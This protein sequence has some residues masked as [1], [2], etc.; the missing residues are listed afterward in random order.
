MKFH[1]KAEEAVQN[2]TLYNKKAEEKQTPQIQP[3]KKGTPK[4]GDSDAAGKW[5]LAA[6]GSFVLAGLIYYRRRRWKK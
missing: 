1:V 6:A 3:D 4:T 5:I 2:V